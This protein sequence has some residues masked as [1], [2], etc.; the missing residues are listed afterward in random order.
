M[1][2]RSRLAMPT[3]L[4]SQL[5]GSL[6]TNT[7]PRLSV[8][9]PPAAP[10][11]R[12]TK[13]KVAAPLADPIPE[14]PPATKAKASPKKEKAKPVSWEEG[15]K[16]WFAK[17]EDEDDKSKMG[18]DGIEKL[19]E[20]MDVSMEGVSSWTE[21]GV[22]RTKLTRFIDPHPQVLPFLLAWKLNAKP[23][24]FGSFYLSDMETVFREPKSVHALSL[25]HLRAHLSR[26]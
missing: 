16:E 22:R 10:K 9:P 24:T 12:T 5:G 1:I 18:G 2:R 6:S 21:L 11:P 25:L 13:A 26:H 20:E 15:L 19:F 8:H 23:G 3:W 7:Y 4:F 17:F 14:A